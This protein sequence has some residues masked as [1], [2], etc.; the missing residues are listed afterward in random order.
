MLNCLQELRSSLMLTLLENQCL[1]LTGER[2]AILSRT[3]NVL[4][5]RISTTL[6]RSTFDL[7]RDLTPP[8]IVS[9]QLTRKEKT[10][11]S[12]KLW[13]RTDLQNPKAPFRY[14]IFTR[15]DVL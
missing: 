2:E 10:K 14:P 15:K 9:Q 3:T 6:P 5:L 13:L 1:M 11:C 7:C 8:S 12:L 4:R